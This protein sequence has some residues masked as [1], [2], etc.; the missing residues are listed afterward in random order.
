MM[1]TRTDRSSGFR[2]ESLVELR[3]CLICSVNIGLNLSQYAFTS[4]EHLYLQQGKYLQKHLFGSNS[5]DEPFF[6]KPLPD[7]PLLTNPY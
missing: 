2:C 3:F 7:K 1:G 6:G 5:P 4:V